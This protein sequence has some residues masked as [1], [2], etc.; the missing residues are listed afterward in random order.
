M[1]RPEAET[2]KTALTALTA[3][4]V[5]QPDS[6]KHYKPGTWDVAC[7]ID[8]HIKRTLPRLFFLLLL[9][10]LLLLLCGGERGHWIGSSEPQMAV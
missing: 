9:L 4:L 1:G 8:R 7:T 3:C 2:E 6:M 5:G 10:L